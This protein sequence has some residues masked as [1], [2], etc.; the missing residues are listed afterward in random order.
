MGL[1]LEL[2]RRTPLGWLQLSHHKSRLLVA[3]AGIAFADVLI[4][5]QLGFQNALYDSN[6]RLN[7]TFLADIILISPQ[8][9]NMQNLATFSR[10]RLLQAAD[11][12]GV[13]S[14]EALYIGLV[15]W[16]NPQTRQKTTVQAI[17][18][19]PEQVALNLP[20]VN[21]QL[22]K[23]KLPETFLFDRA[24]RGEYAQVFQQIDAGKLVTTEVDKRTISI[25]GVFKL[26]A[27][28]GA[29][30]T[31]VSSD[32]NFL[33]L[34][35]RRQAGSISLGLI[36]IQ[37]GYDT[38][39]VATA[40]KAYLKSE[41]VKV[42]TRAEYIKFEE[43]YWKK[44]SPIG[45]IFSLGVSMG[46]MVGVIIVYQVLSTDVNAH[47]KEYATFKAMGYPN[48]YLLGVIFEEAIILAA[49]GFIPGF[50]VPLGLYQ[51]AAN[52][53]NLPIY[54]TAMRAIIVFFLTIIM[55]TLSGAIATRRLQAADPADMF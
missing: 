20:E 7:R 25:G 23:I 47:M 13:K 15:T 5:M 11:V 26:G 12:P 9:R 39:Q 37:P 44:E 16:K 41:D 38:Q 53:T 45:F 31:L 30:G 51:L 33:R 32:E 27:S 49:L 36:N 35:P 8:S 34:F 17:G 29:D 42:L 18:F 28:F 1:I 24:A 4:F 2:Q 19:N 22:D 52:A 10:R 6:T 40:L 55:C 43:D 21:N 48:S 46:F 50:I 3:L 54:M 14:A